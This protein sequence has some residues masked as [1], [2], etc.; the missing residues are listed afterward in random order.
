MLGINNYS[1]VE[2]HTPKQ[3]TIYRTI[4]LDY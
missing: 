4:V 2:R 3:Y 1:K